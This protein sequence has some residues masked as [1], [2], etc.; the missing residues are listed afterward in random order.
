MEIIRC[1]ACP[2]IVLCLALSSAAQ[3]AATP[4][5][6]CA[7]IQLRITDKHGTQLPTSAQDLHLFDGDK[8]P[9]SVQEI[10]GSSNVPL[11]LGILI[12]T[13]NSERES[14]I[15]KEAARQLNPFLAEILSRPEDRLFVLKFDEDTQT[16]K[17]LSR[18]EVLTL[19]TSLTPGGG[20]ALFDA[21]DLASKKMPPQQAGQQYRRALV[22]FSDGHDTASHISNGDALHSAMIGGVMIFIIS[23]DERSGTSYAGEN[24]NKAIVDKL[25]SWT[26]GEAFF[27]AG[28]KDVARAL[29]QIKQILIQIRSVEY[30]PPVQRLDGKLHEFSMKTS[31]KD[32]HIHTPRSYLAPKPA[33][34]LGVGK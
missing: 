3:D 20:T 18:S 28:G 33:I 31:D 24:I 26:G 14:M 30:C 4:R 10:V 9:H 27:P 12:D 21:I 32:V 22:V 16:T 15:Y 6:Q 13:S 19:K 8:E 2:T 17:F 11:R 23:T 7:A 25:T 34:Q 29:S 5:S 1:L